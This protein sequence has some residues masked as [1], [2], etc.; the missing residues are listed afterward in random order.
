MNDTEYVLLGQNRI[1]WVDSVKHLGNYFNTQLFDSTDC[2][3]KRSTFIGSVNKLMSNFGHLQAPVLS[4]I[5]KIFC[6]NFYGSPIWDFN[7]TGF[8]KICITWNIEVRTVLKLLFD[9]HCYFLGPLLIQNHIRHQLQVRGIR[10]LYNMYHSNNTIVCSCVNH[11]IVDV[12]SCI[13]AKFAFV[14]SFGVDIFK[15]TLCEAI[16]QVPL[17]KIT[18]EQQADIK[19][20]R[21]LMFV[22]SEQSFIKGFDDADIDCMIQYITGN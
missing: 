5:F 4:K 7:S 15:H 16:Q 3:M 17:I 2:M 9:T 13:G 19:N 12:N 1:N 14:R 20:L 18:V 8:R 22:R 6:C 21:N 10:F 11:A